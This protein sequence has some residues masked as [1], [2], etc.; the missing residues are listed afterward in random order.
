M[1]ATLQT[2]LENYNIKNNNDNYVKEKA[3]EIEM[4]AME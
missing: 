3:D 1:I 2:K 4:L